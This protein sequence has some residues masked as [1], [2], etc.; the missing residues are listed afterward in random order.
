MTSGAGLDSAAVSFQFSVD[1]LIHPSASSTPNVETDII[2]IGSVV[3]GLAGI[4]GGLP[5]LVVLVDFVGMD[6]SDNLDPLQ[7]EAELFGNQPLGFVFA[8]DVGIAV[9]TITESCQCLVA[10]LAHV[11]TCALAGFP[12]QFAVKPGLEVSQPALV[13]F[14]VLLGRLVQLQDAAVQAVDLGGA[15]LIDLL[16]AVGLDEGPAE[17]VLVAVEVVVGFFN[18]GVLLGHGLEAG[19]LDKLTHHHFS[20]PP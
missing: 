14:S 17:G 10:A 4:G 11:G 7:G 15:G 6:L 19:T 13:L 5:K 1:H 18:L 12:L 8:H 3:E 9:G 16:L 2:V 20:F